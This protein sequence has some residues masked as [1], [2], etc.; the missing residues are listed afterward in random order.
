L[1]NEVSV[2]I[3]ISKTFK[4]EKR[5]HQIC[6]GP[7]LTSYRKKLFHRCNQLYNGLT[8]RLSCAMYTQP[9]SKLRDSVSNLY[10]L[11]MN[12]ARF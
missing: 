2:V 10:C 3:V 6:N 5:C 11:L 8:S 9:A 4:F 7:I 12:E 1:I